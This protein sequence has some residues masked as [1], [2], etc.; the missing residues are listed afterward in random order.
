MPFLDLVGVARDLKPY[1]SLFQAHNDNVGELFLV[2]RGVDATHS[3][4]EMT[5]WVKIWD[6]KLQSV[7]KGFWGGQLLNIEL[8]KMEF[9]QGLKVPYE[10][11]YKQ[12]NLKLHRCVLKNHVA[13]KSLL[14]Y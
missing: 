12:T 3:E 4:I 6:S 10:N 1:A 13:A 5:S 7:Q 14:P 2:D 8:P 11:K 9:E